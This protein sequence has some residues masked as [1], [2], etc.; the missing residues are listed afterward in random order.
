MAEHLTL[1]RTCVRSLLITSVSYAQQARRL[2]LCLSIP[3][4]VYVLFSLRAFHLRDANVVLKG[5]QI[6]IHNHN[7]YWNLHISSLRTKC[8]QAMYILQILSRTQWG[9]EPIILSLLYEA[10]VRSKIAYGAF[11][12]GSAATTHLNKLNV[13]QNHAFRHIVEAIKTIPIAATEAEAKIP[14]LQLH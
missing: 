5:E 13:I 4:C 12:F 6:L 14:P 9:G 1:Q 3:K 7:K 11:F 8:S 10:I 2:S